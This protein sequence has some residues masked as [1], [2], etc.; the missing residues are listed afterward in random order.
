MAAPAGKAVV[1]MTIPAHPYA[2]LFPMLGE[3]DGLAL[4]E[5]ISANK[6]RERIIILDGMILDGRNRQ[7]QLEALGLVDGQL[8]PEGDDLWITR[9]R[10]FNREQDGDALAFV[11]SLNLHRR[12]LT[13]SQRAMVAADLA[14]MRQGERTDRADSS[15]PSANLP[16]VSQSDAAE[17]LHVSTR[18][19]TAATKVREHGAPEL[20]ERVTAGEVS[21]SAAAEVAE[22]PV[23][24]QLVILQSRDPQGFRRAVRNL[25]ANAPRDGR[26][27]MNTRVQPPD[28]LD[29]SPTPPWATRAF[30][31]VVL[32]YL[33]Q[34]LAGTTVLDPACGEGHISAVLMEAEPLVVWAS[35]IWDYSV[36]GVYPPG[37]VGQRDYLADSEPTDGVDW[38]VM[39][40]P[41][42]EKAEQ[43]F[44]KAYAEA[45]VGVAMFVRLG[46]L[47]SK[48]R[49]TR[50][51][52]VTP[53]TVVAVFAEDVPLHMGRWD[54]DG[55]T[56]S[57]YIWLVWVKGAEPKPT[58]W[59]PPGQREA[60]TLADDVER[61][62]AHPVRSRP[63]HIA[64]VHAAS[65]S[66]AISKAEALEVIRA[67]YAGSNGQEL[68]DRLGRKLNTIRKWAWE[69]GVSDRGRLLDNLAKANREKEAS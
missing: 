1:L 17:M 60:L 56:L 57:D 24:D 49:F 5:D 34:S 30:L 61:F 68:A 38:V 21:V 65:E 39:N 36:D 19:V 6:Q 35:D 32:P 54:P 8:P 55:A 3:A 58:F 46:W 47:A 44:H 63:A 14:T 28:D 11:L 22:L 48:G 16:K 31:H 2:K 20:V 69:A 9:Y 52:S 27:V 66:I 12:H 41:F 18:S 59:I 51:F 42:R 15:E 45:Q 23:E 67:E 53:P 62:T 13:D 64:E 43:F 25:R 26:A 29:F 40:P 10:R 4:R 33:G 37:W 7:Q 50:I